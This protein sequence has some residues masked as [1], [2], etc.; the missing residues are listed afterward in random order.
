MGIKRDRDDLHGLRVAN[1]SRPAKKN[2]HR[3]AAVKGLRE[4]ILATE[5]RLSGQRPGDVF[6]DFPGVVGVAQ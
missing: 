4:V 5:R 3:R 2:G 1:V 6:A